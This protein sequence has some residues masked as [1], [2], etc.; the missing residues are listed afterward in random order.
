M[1]ASHVGRFFFFVL[2]P[3]PI[4]IPPCLSIDGTTV[5]GCLMLKS[6]RVSFVV[7][8]PD[9]GSQTIPRETKKMKMKSNGGRREGGDVS[10]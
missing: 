2:I 3:I 8:L 9:P 4:P 10:G 7:L 6:R 1:T 5:F